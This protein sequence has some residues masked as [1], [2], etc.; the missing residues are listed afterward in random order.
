MTKMLEA[1]SD[2][3]L[4]TVQERAA[5]LLLEVSRIKVL[6]IGEV[7]RD[8]SSCGADGGPPGDRA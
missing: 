2:R 7:T 4:T 3:E 5:D 6:R 8:P 1:L